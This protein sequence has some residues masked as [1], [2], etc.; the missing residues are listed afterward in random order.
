V[1]SGTIREIFW[2]LPVLSPL[3]SVVSLVCQHLKEKSLLP[4]IV[5][6]LYCKLLTTKLVESSFFCRFRIESVNVFVLPRF[7]LCHVAQGSHYFEIRGRSV[8]QRRRVQFFFIAYIL[9]NV[10]SFYLCL[11]CL[12][13]CWCRNKIYYWISFIYYLLD[14][15]WLSYACAFIICKTKQRIWKGFI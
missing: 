15:S 11:T 4:K 14:N 9:S 13:Q 5:N 10:L 2:L 1:K 3:L 6:K 8:D 7:D 12:K